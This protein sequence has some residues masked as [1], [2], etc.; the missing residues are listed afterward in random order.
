M[1]KKKII[2]MLSCVIMTVSIF[3]TT[4]FAKEVKNVTETKTKIM[5]DIGGKGN[6]VVQPLTEKEKQR[7]QEKQSLAK[8]YYEEN[9]GNKSSG[10]ITTNFYGQGSS[11]QLG[12]TGFVEEYGYYCGPAAAYS[13]IEG[14]WG[15]ETDTDQYHLASWLGTTTDGTNF[16]S[17]WVDT[18]DNFLPENNYT[19]T[20]AQ[21]YSD[22]FSTIRYDVVWTVNKGYGVIVDTK[23][24][25]YDSIKLIPQYSYVDAKGTPTYHY[26]T[27]DGY[28]LTDSNSLA[29][30]TDSNA[31][32][33]GEYSTSF[34]TL[35]YVS[36]L[37]GIVW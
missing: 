2:S 37:Y 1:N 19:R 33:P 11:R 34:S 29:H 7:D 3:S 10:T 25:P 36:R 32:F 22:W 23:Q 8:K 31:N 27:V 6:G 21:N 18:M 9:I 26:I 4:V 35:S 28:N 13:A 12:F 24:D 15:S 17:K 20:L 5:Q 16:T 14:I 30:F